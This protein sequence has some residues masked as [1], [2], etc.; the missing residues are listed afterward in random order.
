[1][2][3][4]ELIRNV[5]VVGH[6]HHGKTALLDMLINQT[7]EKDWATAKAVIRFSSDRNSIFRRITQD[8]LIREQY[9][10]LM[11]KF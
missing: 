3:C 8:K 5:A 1:M 4:R 9:I 10:F 2:E 7:H 6:L 11:L